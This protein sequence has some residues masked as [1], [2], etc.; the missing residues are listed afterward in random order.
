MINDRESVYNQRKM[1]LKEYRKMKLKMLTRDFRVK[2]TD[3]DIAHANT[4]TTEAQI[5]QFFISMLNNR[6]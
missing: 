3:E 5:D 4:L 1:S 6:W 2:L